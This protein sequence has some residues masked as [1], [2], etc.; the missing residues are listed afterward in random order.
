MTAA[1]LFGFRAPSGG[2]G[3]GRC[4]KVLNRQLNFDSSNNIQ[5][6]RSRMSSASDCSFGLQQVCR[7]F[8]AGG[9]APMADK[10]EGD[11]TSAAA[12]T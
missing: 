2:G 6:D 5:K 9:R 7:S 10:Y 12:T 11:Q 4:I 1:N 3:G 8:V